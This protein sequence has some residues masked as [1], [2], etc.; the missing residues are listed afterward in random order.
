[1]N[2]VKGS[3]NEGSPTPSKVE[4]ISIDLTAEINQ[5]VKDTLS[6]I[7]DDNINHD[8]SK[9]MNNLRE[10]VLGFLEKRMTRSK[11]SSCVSLNVGGVVCILN[12]SI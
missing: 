6:Q 9:D 10:Q 12:K 3:S 1:M 4:K 2:H 5:R 11:P 8:E 7:F